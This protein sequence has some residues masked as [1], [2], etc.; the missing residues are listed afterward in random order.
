LSRGTFEER[1][2]LKQGSYRSSVQEGGKRRPD[3]EYL[4]RGKKKTEIPKRKDDPSL[5]SS[6]VELKRDARKK[7]SSNKTSRRKGHVRRSFSI[8]DN[9]TRKM[10]RG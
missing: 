10:K 6:R 7:Q 4:K 8:V 1:K 5:Y 9:V 3:L 2:P